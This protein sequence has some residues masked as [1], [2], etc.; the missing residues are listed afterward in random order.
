MTLDIILTVLGAICIILGIVGCILP[1]LPGIPLSYAGIILLQ[2][3][4]W[5]DFSPEFLILWALIVIIVQIA[6]YYI[7]IWGTKKFGGG[8]KGMWGSAIGVVLGIFI[9]PPWGLIFLPFLG[10]V[11]GELIDNK[12][13]EV[14]L[15][16]GL[17]SFIGFLAGTLIKLAVAFI[18]A[19]F[20]FR[21]VILHFWNL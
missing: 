11:V 19:F 15:K 4:S 7:P 10:A 16:A 9:F 2:F 6:D 1:L 12:E 20:F 5:V 17:G 13:P 3:T 14:A 8:K 21:E 18:L